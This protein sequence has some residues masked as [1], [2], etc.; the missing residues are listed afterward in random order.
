MSLIKWNNRFRPTISSLVDD[1]FNDDL[2][3]PVKSEWMPA[4]NVK[5]TDDAFMLEVA[6]PGME[7]EDFSIKLEK[8]VLTVKA[9][10]SKEIDEKE[11]EYTRKEFSY[12]SFSRSFWIPEN[13]EEDKIEASY[14][15]GVL[16]VMI[17][18]TEEIVE[19]SGTTIEIQ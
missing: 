1:W 13:T 12:K 17:P 3:K 16:T 6:A 10:K 5:E 7:K 2:F 4:A 19:A 9:E 8:G 15:K 11:D 14:D 18:K